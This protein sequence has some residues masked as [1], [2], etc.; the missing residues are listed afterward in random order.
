M[1][2]GAM[3]SRLDRLFVLLES[4]SSAATR[5]AA[6]QQLGQVQRLHP[7]ELHHLLARI[8]TLLHSPSWDTRIAAG[9]AVEAVVRNVPAWDPPPCSQMPVK[10]EERENAAS[11]RMS[12]KTFE[13]E[14]VLMQGA[15]LAG[16]EGREFDP[17]EGDAR[18]AGERLVQQRAAINEQ[19]G[20]PGAADDLVSVEDLE[21]D[22]PMMEDMQNKKSVA[23]VVQETMVNSGLSSREINRARRV[24]RLVAKQKSRDAQDE[25][26]LPESK[27]AKLDAKGEVTVKQ[28]EEEVPSFPDS[29]PDSTGS[30]GEAVEWPFESFCEQLSQDLL[31]A[32]WEVRHGAATAMREV[33]RIH[34]TGAGRA[35]DMDVQ[36]MEEA[37]NAWLEDAALRVVCVLAL[38]RFGDF[39]SDQVVAPVRETCSQ[40]LGVVVRLMNQ[41]GVREVAQVLLT[42]LR[43][44]EWEARHGGLLGLKYVLAVRGKE[45]S[46][47]LPLVMPSILQGLNDSVEDV[48]AVAAAA[49]IPAA[50]E[51]ASRFPDQLGPTVQRLWDLL[52]EQDELAAA[53]NSFMGLLASLLSQGA[54]QTLHSPQ[55][56]AAR[57]PLLWPFLSHTSSAVRRSTLQTLATLAGGPLS[58]GV[59]LNPGEPSLLQHA[60]RHVYQRALLE[61]DPEIQALAEEVWDRLLQH[62]PLEE[63]L[64]AAC[65][66]ASAWLCLA[67]QPV[68]MSF[69]PAMLIISKLE[70]GEKSRKA[71]VA[72]MLPIPEEET[73]IPVVPAEQKYYI[74]G[75]DSPGS[76]ASVVRA[77][78]MACRMLGKLSTLLVKP[79][80]GLEQVSATSPIECYV[81]VLLVYLQ[82]KSALQRLVVGLVVAEWARLEPESARHPELTTKL[83][84]CLAE[85]VYF[86]EIA[87]SFT[88]L[89][90]ETKDFV[91]MLRHYRVPLQQPPVLTLEQISNLSGSAAQQALIQ[92]KLKPK[93]AES[94]EERRK[95]IQ[96]AVSQTSCHQS[97]L[98]IATQASLAGAVTM[99]GSLPEK[100]NPVV[101]P[102]MDAIKKEQCE[103]L[104]R[105]A[106]EHLTR[107]M[108]LCVTREPSPNHKVVNNLCTFL[109]SDPEFTPVILPVNQQ[110]ARDAAERA[111]LRRS[112]SVTGRGPGRPPTIVASPEFALEELMSDEDDCQK[113]KELQ[114]RGAT[115]ALAALVRHFGAQLP[116]KLPRL[117]ESLLTPLN[118]QAPTP[119]E[120]EAGRVAAESLVAGLQ[121]LEVVLPSLHSELQPQIEASLPRLCSLLEHEY[122]AVRHMGARVLGAL[123]RR[124]SV[125]VVAALVERVLP[126]LAAPEIVK[127]QGAVESVACLVEALGIHIVP[128]AVLMVVPLLGRM[129]DQDPAVRMMAT[130]CFATL[131]QL[132]P[133][134]GGVPEPP[135]LDQALGSRRAEQKRFLEQLFNP[136][137]IED[138]KVPVPLRADLRS[139]QQ[140][141]QSICMLAGDHYR[142]SQEFKR[143]RAP[144]CAPLPSLVVCPPTLTGHWVDE[145][146]KFLSKQHLNPLQYVGPPVERER[147]RG[148][149]KYHNLIIASYD[150]IRKDINFFRSIHWNYCILDEGHVIKNGKT[151]SSKAI[152]QLVANHRLILSGTPIQN[153][154]LELWSLFDFLMPSFLGTERQFTARYSR[155][156]LASRDPKSSPREQEAGVLAMES[157]HRQVLP[158]L[159]RRMKEDVLQDLPPKITQDYFCEL[160]SLQRQL[161]EDF[162]RTQAHQTLHE[163]LARQPD[164]AGTNPATT[165]RYHIF[166][167]EY[168]T[169]N[170]L[171]QLLLDCGIGLPPS[172]EQAETI[173]VNQ[174]RA[175]IFCQLKAMLDIVEKDLLRAHMPEVTY[176]RLDGS[177]PAG[178]RHSVVSRF[179]SDPSID[180]LLLTTQVG[181]LGLN[182]TG[183]DTVIFVEHDWNPMKDLQA[184]DRAHRIGQ[185]KVKFKLLTANTVISSENN[186]LESM[187]SVELLDLFMLERRQSEGEHSASS[188]Q[189]SG[190][191]LS[192]GGVLASLPALWDNS[193]YEE[194]YDLTNFLQSLKRT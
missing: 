77:R 155:P 61:T 123:S 115:L 2:Y 140:T 76:E 154:V 52:G 45:D 132:M 39:V 79:M 17:E 192:M 64:L 113:Q 4:G 139:Y 103:P 138:Y 104:Q 165:N 65:P 62:C 150:I 122:R 13:L 96:H 56:L 38:D 10:K 18:S 107:L 71:K 169:K 149:V 59:P 166:Q 101:K 172:S 135:G 54:A 74:G 11:G 9:Q 51:L 30:W 146:E 19:L 119:E 112:T 44:S 184:M 118:E 136:S 49:L 194:E 110:P 167:T 68:R 29:V 21:I 141:L 142:R 130:H 14:K 36:E 57:L 25:E 27:R 43:R 126:L 22:I 1:T 34:G 182:L 151:K 85:T 177:V 179:N 191:S 147:L 117:W 60:L 73:P 55:V 137:T 143:T 32:S 24:A 78:C 190:S 69:D 94:L 87:L 41:Q 50:C 40:T 99:L 156:I 124:S 83:H 174:H 102:L 63:V 158:F 114:R 171:M 16:S 97:A 168:I 185:K 89:L 175:L 181:G 58:L 23:T 176:L 91:A 48:G 161:Y 144:D 31:S 163:S 26:C 153:N 3:T 70:S 131:I 145:V 148:R 37:H 90:Q 128:Y 75:G 106:S 81:K 120:G 84:Q 193:Q 12:F 6:A 95:A 82:S 187:G 80:P 160:S 152:K 67:M 180:V 121:V 133:L 186:S 66:Y 125:A 183:A 162:Q 15:Q 134:D 7:H 8:S 33:L 111:V 88:K 173:V 98:A 109:R 105:L 188:S 47:L 108:E 100:L 170:Y 92:S 46:T 5:R 129:S 178:Q 20:V 72:A 116:E 93:T 164:S 42:L 86:D 53:S 127:R 189:S 157:L 35:A 28:E 159:L